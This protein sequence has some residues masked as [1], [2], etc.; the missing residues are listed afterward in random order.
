MNDEGYRRVYHFLCA[1]WALDNI[2]KKRIKI[3]TFANLNDPFE[4]QAAKFGYAE[5]DKYLTDHFEKRCGL[6]CFCLGWFNP[7]MWAHYADRHKGIV[8]GFD[9][10]SNQVKTVRYVKTPVIMNIS[11]QLVDAVHDPKRRSP[12]LLVELQPCLE[13]KICTKHAGWSHEQEVRTLPNL[14]NEE[15]A[16][17][18]APFDEDLC[19]REVILGAR[20][21]EQD[22]DVRN[23]VAT[24]PR[25]VVVSR[26]KLRAES[27]S[28][29][30]DV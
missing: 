8:L 21:E 26:A 12:N 4:L 22:E 14:W 30:P 5:L 16:R 11:D 18:F 28:L 17:Y 25:G 19:L 24:F 23:L 20:C 3:S 15:N 27:F 13:K 9:V 7:V 29:S 1:K 6:L 2:R 10:P